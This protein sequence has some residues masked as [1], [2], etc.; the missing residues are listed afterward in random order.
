[1]DKIFLRE[2]VIFVKKILFINP[3]KQD[4]IGDKWEIISF[5]KNSSYQNKIFFC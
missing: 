5:E 2:P 4:Y 3:Q 1:M